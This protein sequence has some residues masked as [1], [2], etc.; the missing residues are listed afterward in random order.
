MMS[1][2][3][4]LVCNNSVLDYALLYGTEGDENS[5]D[6][7]RAKRIR[8]D[9]GTN[10]TVCKEKNT[11]NRSNRADGRETRRPGSKSRGAGYSDTGKHKQ[12]SKPKSRNKK[13][14]R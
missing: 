13:V 5:E 3:F 2:E 6:N 7:S 9:N 4:V 14:S 11:D 10:K 8:K 12:S 1:N